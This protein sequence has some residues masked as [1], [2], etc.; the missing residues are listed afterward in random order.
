VVF[1]FSTADQKV[2][3]KKRQQQI[4]KL[5]NG[6][7]K[8]EKSVVEGRRN[9]TPQAIAKRVAKLFGKKQAAQ[10]FD[11]EMKPL[12]K[13]QQS[14]QPKSQR[15]CSRPTHRFAF[16]F[17]EKQVNQDEQYDGYSVVV[18]TVPQNRPNGGADT[19]FTKFKE[20]NYSEQMNGQFKGPLAVSPVFL[21]SPRRVEAL[22][23]L[24][25]ITL[26]LYYLVQRMYR[27]TVPADAPQKDRRTTTRAI[28]HAFESYTLLI[29]R[30]RFGREVRPTHLTP[31]QRELL[32]R[33]GFSTPAQI[34]A[35]RLPRA[36][37]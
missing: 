2:V 21:H 22:V 17:H 19:L 29:H 37:T 4:E 30:T 23:F 35:Q 32:N 6:L 10:Y 14:K 5:K 27:Q 24:M 34:L 15:G 7:A 26:M 13:K 33:L 18:T 28:L 3:C 8:I 31:R 25:V 12:S 9:T 20:Q 11:W 36:P 1:V 16:R